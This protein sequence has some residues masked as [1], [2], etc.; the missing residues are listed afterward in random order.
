VGDVELIRVGR[1]SDAVGFLYEFHGW[2]ESLRQT[3]QWVRG[4]R[5]ARKLG[6]GLRQELG[7][8]RQS[9]APAGSV[10]FRTRIEPDEIRLAPDFP[11]LSFPVSSEGRSPSLGSRKR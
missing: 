1:N 3:P 8:L 4:T 10:R 7:R 6:R 2:D 9:I 11:P 5:V